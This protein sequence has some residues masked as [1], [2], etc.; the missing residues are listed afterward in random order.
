MKNFNLE[1]FCEMF[2][3]PKNDIEALNGEFKSNVNLSDQDIRTL[4]L[5]HLE[6]KKIFKNKISFQYENVNFSA[7]DFN[8]ASHHIGGLPIAGNNSNGA[9][10]Q[11]LRIIDT[12]NIYV[13]SS[14]VFP[15]SGSSNPTLTIVALGLRLGRHLNSFLWNKYL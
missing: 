4:D 7:L 12:K 15:N 13:C 1:Y 5:L 2:P 8:D 14:A 6:L 9:V 10:D 3:N 11:D